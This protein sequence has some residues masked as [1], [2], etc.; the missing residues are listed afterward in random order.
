[1][2]ANRRDEFEI[3]RIL[4]AAVD[5]DATLEELAKVDRLVTGRPELAS[6]IADVMSQE[7][8]LAWHSTKSRH[9]G[10]LRDDLVAEIVAAARHGAKPAADDSV[11]VSNSAQLVPQREN[12]PGTAGR[13]Y[14]Y[15]GALA[16][17]I[18]VA[19]GWW[20]GFQAGQRHGARPRHVVQLGGEQQTPDSA[21]DRAYMARFVQGTACLWSSESEQL[22]VTDHAL[23]RG[24]ALNLLE[25]LAELQIDWALGQAVLKIEGPA[26][27]VLTADR[28]A[29]LSHGKLVADVESSGS[30]FQ[31]TTPNG[32]IQV[33]D[34]AKVGLAVAG[35][36][37]QLHVFAGQATASVPWSPNQPEPKRVVVSAGRSLK[38]AAATDGRV[39]LTEGISSEDEFASQR[40]MGADNLH[41][42]QAYVDEV[43]RAKP[44]IY[45][46][47]EADSPNQVK[48]VA[49]D[50]YH[51]R[52]SGTVEYVRSG[53]NRV[54]DLGSAPTEDAYKTFLITD[55]PIAETLAGGYAVEF[56]VKPSH[57]HWAS[58]AGL[59]GP[60]SES[61]GRS[62][63]GL[64]LELGGPRAGD[65]V[66]E[67]PGRF[68]FL[69]R[70]P[71]S[72]EPL[73]GT[74]IFSDEPYELRTW[75]H[76]A[77]VKDGDRTSLYVN[78]QLVAQGEDPSE[79]PTGLRLIVGQLDEVQDYRRFIGQLDEL[80]FYPRPLTEAEIL[81][82]FERARHSL[83]KGRRVPTPPTSE[84][85]A[86]LRS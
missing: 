32:E 46:R 17:M 4:M 63:H 52:I 85:A 56:W 80:A 43:M 57:Y 50:R 19:A 39:R 27:L 76:V 73:T 37:V 7:S 72:T 84:N 83:T 2:S 18:V 59:L 15:F 54:L 40:S 86:D 70:S 21:A 75:Q 69:H 82:H 67:H 9:D 64:L 62:P 22:F 81:R 45:W 14:R 58:L 12:D 34:H 11:A 55:E 33:A 10:R 3:T 51:G 48:N 71:P 36:E 44:L 20:F 30:G 13:F 1:M 29:S 49:G 47:F 6:V 61:D 79:L 74:S 42:S 31:L 16:A 26:G 66:I 5:G 25:G 41:I 65:S 68:R 23:R 8:W 35:G 53:H 78:G 28:G 38:I 60:R 77:A 24:E